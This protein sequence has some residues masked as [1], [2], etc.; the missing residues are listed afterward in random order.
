MAAQ[1]PAQAWWFSGRRVALTDI[2][3]WLTR[4]SP[5]QAQLFPHGVPSPAAKPTA[6]L[7]GTRA[8]VVTAGPGSGKTAVLGLISALTHPEHRRTV[9]ID[10]IQLPPQRS[11]RSVRST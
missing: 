3:T 1:G 10:A 2:T 7:L 5:Q 8:L 6:Q 11:P 9:P 4:P